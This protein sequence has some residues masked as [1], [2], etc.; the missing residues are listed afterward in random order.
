M[1]NSQK[2]QTKTI[3][4]LISF[5]VLLVLAVLGLVT[6]YY[7]QSDHVTS[8]EYQVAHL[9]SSA[10]DAKKSE[11]TSAAAMY[12]EIPELGVK[13]RLTDETRGLTYTFI[14]SGTVQTVMFSTEE[15]TA[16]HLNDSYPCTSQKMAGGVIK[17]F[18]AGDKLEQV[19]SAITSTDKKIGNYYYL[20]QAPQAP[21]SENAL[22][23]GQQQVAIKAV[24]KAFD[25]LE[26]M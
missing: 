2:P 14:D 5:I 21:C 10:E 11:E 1:E 18:K 16:F 9:K 19:P 3:A 7:F 25:S 8:L 22:I 20:V 4:G 12:R 23:R 17:R 26:A 15:L 6:A 24:L 13:Y